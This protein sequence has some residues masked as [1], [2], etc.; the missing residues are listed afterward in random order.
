MKAVKMILEGGLT[1]KR[2]HVQVAG[3]YSA[4]LLPG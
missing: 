2:K 1:L 4:D 3:S